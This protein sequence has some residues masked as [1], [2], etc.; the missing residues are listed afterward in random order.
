MHM[1][2][3]EH[4]KLISN[5]RDSIQGEVDAKI[6]LA[7]RITQDRIVQLEEALKIAEKLNIVEMQ[8]NATNQQS[9]IMTDDNLLNNNPLYLYGSKALKVEIETLSEIVVKKAI[10][11]LQRS[12]KG[13][14]CSI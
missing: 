10:H 6:K 1:H 12:T 8:I 13:K 3:N 9:V 2:S 5:K 7:K 14:I 4:Y 11:S